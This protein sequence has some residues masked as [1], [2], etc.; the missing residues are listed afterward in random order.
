[1]EP[2]GVQRVMSILANYFAEHHVKVTLI[3]LSEEPAFYPLHESVCHIK[4]SIMGCNRFKPFRILGTALRSLNCISKT[5]KLAEQI[6][7]D[8]ALCFMDMPSAVGTFAL[9]NTGVPV[10]ISERMCP[11]YGLT[12]RMKLLKRMA[13]SL[14]EGYVFQTKQ[15]QSCYSERI[16]I[17]SRVIPNPLS[18]GIPAPWEAARTRRIVA[19]G[20]LT[21]QKGFDTLLYA[22]QGVAEKIP[23]YNLTIYGNGP[24]RDDLLLLS[25]KLNIQERVEFID[26]V[27]DIW[28]RIKDAACLVMPSRSEGFP[29]ILLEALAL[30]LPVVAT[31]C[32]NGPSEMIRNG[33]NGR[34]VPV[35]DIEALT[36]A[37]HHTLV[38]S[39]W[40][41][42][43]SKTAEQIC[44]QYACENI[45]NQWEAY[46]SE[47]LHDSSVRKQKG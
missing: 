12:F 18:Q 22:F 46:L 14:A 40:T 28:E 44:K 35:D 17:R 2:G 27:P 4:L 42:H 13:Y 43:L 15:A 30:G 10:V 33:E 34:L 9:K 21:E 5:R 45:C 29:N 3:T 8:V 25:R 20:R 16:R 1:M 37:I 7:P 41:D 23:D 6:R 47:I 26:A 36:E 19:V 11:G 24:L 31:D 38:D 39:S 32:P